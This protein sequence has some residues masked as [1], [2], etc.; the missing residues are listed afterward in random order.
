MKYPVG[1]VYYMKSKVG[2][3]NENERIVIVARRKVGRQT[4]LDVTDIN[5]NRVNNVKY[6]KLRKRP[7]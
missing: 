4:I 6:H 2:P 1:G 5:N 7:R 3:L